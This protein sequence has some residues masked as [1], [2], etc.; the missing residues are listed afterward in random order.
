MKWVA[1]CVGV[2]VG[3]EQFGCIAHL[4]VIYTTFVDINIC[5]AD[6]DF[7]YKR[8]SVFTINDGM[9]LWYAWSSCQCPN[10]CTNVGDKVVLATWA[11]AWSA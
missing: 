1:L 6:V 7:P 5:F 11:S 2:Q 9:K 3:V 4:S 10:L 8:F